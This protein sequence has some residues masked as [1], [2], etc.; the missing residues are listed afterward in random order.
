VRHADWE[1][2]FGMNGRLSYGQFSILGIFSSRQKGIPTAS[3][4][5]NFG[6]SR[7]MTE[8]RRWAAVVE[9]TGDPSS[10]LRLSGRVSLDGYDY[11][12]AYPYEF[13]QDDASR[14][15]CWAGK[16]HA[17]WDTDPSN[18]LDAGL[19]M[20]LNPR[21]DYHVWSMAGYDYSRNAPYTI[22]SV[23]LQDTYQMFDEVSFSLALRAD[24]HSVSGWLASPRISIV[25]NPSSRNTIKVLYGEAFRAPSFYELYYD[26]GTAI[27]SNPDLKSER[28]KTIE[29]SV[30][31]RL[32][33]IMYGSVSLYQFGIQDLIE[34]TTVQTEVV[35]Q[36]QN[37][38]SVHARGIECELI[39]RL[40][41]GNAA[42]ISIG[43][44]YSEGDG[45]RPE[46]TNSPRTILGASGSLK[47]LENCELALRARYE[48]GR[49]TIA[50]T[51][52]DPFLLVNAF[53][54]VYRIGERCDLSLA[55]R[56]VFDAHYAYPAG[57]EHTQASLTQ[58]GRTFDLRAV[59]RW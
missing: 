49:L 56:N 16:V 39:T 23:F 9:Y 32:N 51:P 57:L 24:R 28:V 37:I 45:I 4:G 55:V 59:V 44:Q 41:S 3:Y 53:L 10:S 35:G 6:D 25:A 1:K 2:G 30:E 38:G 14:G 34:Q 43:T 36:H 46:L 7:A 52:T 29:L 18:R 5:T 11:A 33:S 27:V 58:D 22:A 31:H 48:T 13:V 12:G 8:D 21:A 50:G 20:R 15:R 42:S 26:D 54:H 17:Q 40:P 47:L 19:E